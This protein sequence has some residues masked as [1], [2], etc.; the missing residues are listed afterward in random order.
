M[1]DRI[2]G[3][4]RARRT[5]SRVVEAPR[6]QPA[7]SL[8]REMAREAREDRL[9]GLA[10]EIAFFG[11]LSLFPALLVMAATLAF[12]G[13][14][15]GNDVADQARDQVLGFLQRVLTDDAEDTVSAVRELFVERKAGLLTLSALSGLWATSR[16]VSS[17]MRALDV[18]YDV[19]ETRSWLRSKAT[20][21]A[22]SLGTVAVAALMLAL[23]VLGPLLG[24]GGAVADALGLGDAF[25]TA[26][27][28]ARLPTVAVVLTLWAATVYHV[29]PDHHS[30]WR[31]A[32]PGA[33]VAAGFWTAASFGLRLGLAAAAG[34]NQVFGALG[35]FLILLVWIYALGFGL[36]VGGELNGILERRRREGS[37]SSVRP[38]TGTVP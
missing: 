13:S 30:R 14:L 26:W 15:V 24:A 35:G 36:V 12:L 5:W 22:L 32:L 6:L 2:P 4:A 21:L 37:T 10:A 3:A 7:I 25:A 9:T 27:N 8:G 20:A 28:W 1:G 17:V 23:I 11:V 16:G 33:G 34:G 31:D 18:A 29:A 19:P 38:A